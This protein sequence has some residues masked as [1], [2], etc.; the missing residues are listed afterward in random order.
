MSPKSRMLLAILINFSLVVI[1]AVS[2]CL[3]ER[4]W[5]HSRDAAIKEKIRQSYVSKVEKHLDEVTSFI[6]SIAKEYSGSCDRQ[7]VLHMRKQLFNIPGAIELG[8]IEKEG[9]HGVVVCNSWGENERVEVRQPIPHKGFLITGPHTINSLEKPIFVIKQTTGNFEYNII[10]KKSSVDAFVENRADIVVSTQSQQAGTKYRDS[11][12][13]ENLSYMI[14]PSAYTNKVYNLYFIPTTILLFIVCFF[15][16]T[17]KWVRGIEKNTLRRKIRGHY[18]YNEYQP[19]IDTRKQK[20]FSIEVFLRSKDGVNAKDSIDKI[21]SLD[22]CVEHTMLQ[23]QQIEM[24]FDRDFIEQNSF[25]VNI[26]SLHLE[27]DSFVEKMLGLDGLIRNSLIFEVVEDEDLMLQKNIIK[28]HMNILK[29][30]GY[31]FAIDD[32]GI[33]YSGLS[34]ISEFDFDI[35]KADKI[36]IVDTGKNTTILKSIIALTNELG[37]DCIA[38]GV[39]TAFDNE[40]ISSLGIHLQQGWYHGRPMS[41]EQIAVYQVKIPL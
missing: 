21:K 40:K 23:I 34:Y 35:V 4:T 39:E 27:S 8:V 11:Q 9:D 24:S 38:E 22:L 15:L 6:A 29:N 33:E 1:L 17:P 19:I 2:L 30:N 20:L 3:L 5:Q 10:I 25:Q 14:S 12:V 31:R 7:L 36:F 32:F 13:I 18:Y 37:I 26:L 16:V 28:Q 41:A